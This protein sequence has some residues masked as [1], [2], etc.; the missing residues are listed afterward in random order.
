M[1]PLSDLLVFQAVV[2]AGSFVKAAERLGIT[3]SGVSKRIS[4]YEERLNVRLLHRTTRSLSVTDAGQS[5]YVRGQSILEEVQQAELASQNAATVPRGTLRVAC[6]DAFAL[7]VLVPAL[8]K[9]H[10]QYPDVKVTILQGDGPI[11]LID[12]RVDVAVRFERPT[13][14]GFVARPLTEDPWVVCASPEYLEDAG[15]PQV[16]ADLRDHRCLTIRA[17]DIETLRWD[18]A[19]GK[20]R[21]SVEVE[22]VLSGIG[23]VV[24]N[25]A[26]Q[27]LGIARLASFLVQESLARGELLRLLAAFEPPNRR[28]IY[29]VYPHREFIPLNVR[30]FIDHMAGHLAESAA[31]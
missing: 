8:G 19:D 17:R 2:D 18:F 5:L 4:R 27:G 24:K 23:L 6:S 10:R 3:P 13:H 1:D 20:R 14:A 11:N 28:K 26:I 9:F 25:A 29:A 7:H 30:L 16:P 31:P 22:S 15:R 21:F 12:E